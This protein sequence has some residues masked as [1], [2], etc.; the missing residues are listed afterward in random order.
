MSTNL[1]TAVHV[2][3]TSSLEGFSQQPYFDPKEFKRFTED[4]FTPRTPVTIQLGKGEYAAENI[5]PV[6][7]E[8]QREI[9]HMAAV[10]LA[11]QN[12]TGRDHTFMLTPEAL[13]EPRIRARIHSIQQMV[14][15]RIRTG[16]AMMQDRIIKLREQGLAQHPIDALARHKGMVIG[17]MSSKP[18]P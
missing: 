16:W 15:T 10:M 2:P 6:P 3:D 5:P 11:W 4:Q 12:I 17:D 13:Q 9:N 1:I 7:L 14:V 18:M 8:I